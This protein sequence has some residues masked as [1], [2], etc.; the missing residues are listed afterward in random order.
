MFYIRFGYLISTLLKILFVLKISFELIPIQY[1]FFQ[2]IHS[3]N[4]Y[5]LFTRTGNPASKKVNIF[6]PIPP[7]NVKLGDLDF[8]IHNRKIN[9]KII[10]TNFFNQFLYRKTIIYKKVF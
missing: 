2:V 5:S 1:Y 6:V 8:F 9:T 10:F 3:Y 4:L 7:L